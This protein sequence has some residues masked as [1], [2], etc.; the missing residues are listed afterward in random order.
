[1]R[2]VAAQSSVLVQS[3]WG[4]SYA[5]YANAVTTDRAGNIYVAGGTTS[6]GPGSPTCASLS[7]LKYSPLGNLL[8]QRLWSNGSFAY[9]TGI[10]LDGS[11]N[12]YITGVLY[13]TCNGHSD[14][15]L[16]KL[17]PGGN[18]LWQKI[19]SQSP[20]SNFNAL[21][22]DASGNVFVT[23]YYGNGEGIYSYSDVL[24]MRFN[25]TGEPC[26]AKVVGRS[27]LGQRCR[28]SPRPL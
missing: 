24:I 7:I 15:L 12:I 9:A 21:A 19:I 3:L 20:D 10:A 5:D 17:D 22:V 16:L 2:P 26:L 27:T 13:T 1:M 18:L 14:G 23:G 25:S 28:S 8:W 6:Y 4:G 11:G